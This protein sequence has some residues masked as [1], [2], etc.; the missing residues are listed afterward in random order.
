AT[1]TVATG[2]GVTVR[3]TVPV[4][5]S[6]VAVT[7]ALPALT[8]VT[9]PVT[10]SIVANDVGVTDHVTVRPV[11]VLPF[12][13]FVVAVRVVVR[14]STT[15]G[16]E[17]E[18]VTVATGIGLTVM[19][20]VPF[21]PSL[22]P[23]IVALPAATPRTSPFASTEAIVGAL[24]DHV[25]ARLRSTFPAESFVVAVSRVVSPT[26]TVALVGVTVTVSTGTRSTVTPTTKVAVS[27]LA[28]IDAF[29][30][31]TPVTPPFTAPSVLVVPDAGDTVAADALEDQ[32]TVRP[33]S[34]LP[35]ES[36]TVAVNVTVCA[37]SI[38]V[39][40]FGLT[41]TD[42]TDGGAAGRT[43]IVALPLLPSLVAVT[44]AEP[45]AIALTTPVL[46]TV[47][48]AAALVDHVMARPE[49][50]APFASRAVAESVTEPPM[51]RLAV[52]G[53]TATDATGIGGGGVV[54]VTT[55]CA[56]PVLPSAVAVMSVV[57]APTPVTRPLALTVAI[58]L[59]ADAHVMGRPASVLPFA[60]VATA[61]SALDAPTSSVAEP[62][63][64]A[65]A[66]TGMTVTVI[67]DDAL[68]PSTVPLTVAE[69]AETAVTLPDA[70]T[71]ATCDAE[72]AHTMAR[73]LSGLE[74]ASY[75]TV[76]RV[77]VPPVTRVAA[78][79]R[80]ATDATGTCT[81][82]TVVTV[83]APLELAAIC[84]FP[85]DLPVTTPADDTDTILVS[86]LD[87]NTA[88]PGIS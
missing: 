86:A 64:T 13:S 38:V 66:A 1:V 83:D 37:E 14:C 87:Q 18:I 42:A 31:E 27:L 75:A 39:A 84:V 60:S 49:S 11:N 9:T 73:P 81:T 52:P 35:A 26:C 10:G 65:T 74:L 34:L 59:F 69:P 61:S 7:V 16:L 54:A 40:P 58:D 82:V 55:T 3:V 25:T 48:I 29:P 41:V 8:P 22:A 50:A 57:P 68:L 63:V 47:A 21:F 36:R 6:L 5:V 46:D 72:L 2:A 76:C 15:D 85:I 4:F 78:E 33:L 17:G 45:G 24:D 77:T 79:G 43:K 12:A 80:T 32:L 67:A 70:S 56:V 71:V 88:A 51:L 28:R 53:F 44:V 20:D 62:G 19:A 30:G 23:V